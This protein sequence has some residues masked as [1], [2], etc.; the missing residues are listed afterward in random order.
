MEHSVLALA[1]LAFGLLLFTVGARPAHSIDPSGE[2]AFSSTF[3]QNNHA[4]ASGPAS[5]K[6]KPD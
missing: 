5:K 3:S 6:K 4:T 2:D 1:I